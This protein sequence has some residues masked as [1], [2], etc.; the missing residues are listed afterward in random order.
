MKNIHYILFTITFAT[1]AITD[2]MFISRGI[3]TPVDDLKYVFMIVAALLL[4]FE[5][6]F[7]QKKNPGKRYQRLFIKEFNNINVIVIVFIF[8][9]L[10]KILISG[11]FTMETPKEIIYLWIPIIYAFLL[12]NKLSIKDV[13]KYF[14][15]LLLCFI[16]GY[17]LEIYDKLSISNFFNISYSKSYSPFES[18]Y[19]SG[20]FTSIFLYFLYR[21]KK[22]QSTISFIFVLMTFKRL[23]ILFSVIMLITTKIF[24]MKK[25]VKKSTVT[26]FKLFFIVS[27]IIIYFYLRPEYIYK[28]NTRFNID[29]DEILMGRANI[30]NTVIDSGFKSYGYGS[31]TDLVLKIFPRDGH[32]HLDLVKIFMETTIVG[33]SIFVNNLWNVVGKN[34]Y[35]V[36]IML[37]Q[38]FNILTSHSLRG[39]F[40]WTMIYLIIGIIAIDN[41]KVK[42]ETYAS[43]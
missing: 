38:F 17:G 30:F 25:D 14:N 39:S 4:I 24:N 3:N 27:P 13:D 20:S 35:A 2:G 7:T 36:L 8:I 34:R 6:K 1:K 10:I 11:K 15:T 28:I 40:S 19:M 16:I 29:L 9:S 18:A 23:S 31:T 41:S 43:R 33:L 26:L 22:L 5:I 42:E 12:L 37:Y 32:L 21:D